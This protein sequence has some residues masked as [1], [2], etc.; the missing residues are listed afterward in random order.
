MTPKAPRKVTNMNALKK[1]P[2]PVLATVGLFLYGSSAVAF[3]K[4]CSGSS[5]ANA[6]ATI[7]DGQSQIFH[8]NCI[9]CKLTDVTSAQREERYGNIASSYDSDIGWDEFFMGIGLVR[10]WFLGKATGTVLEIGCGTG[11]NFQHYPKEVT[12]LVA[13][14]AVLSMLEQA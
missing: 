2:K 13:T 12:R 8:G 4:Y 6:N 10:W 9:K 1:A 11:R 14:D 7:S 3:Y 5:N